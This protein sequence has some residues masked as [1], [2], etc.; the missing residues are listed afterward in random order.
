M[1][2]LRTVCLDFDGVV[3]QRGKGA[4]VDNKMLSDP[5][6]G[7]AE[8]IRQ[9]LERYNVVIST[10]RAASVLAREALRRFLVR[11][12]LTEVES[13]RVYI[14][15]LKPVADLYIGDRFY[16]LDN[17]PS[18]KDLEAAMRTDSRESVVKPTEWSAPIQKAIARIEEVDEPSEPPLPEEASPEP[19]PT[20]E[21][22]L[23]SRRRRS[24]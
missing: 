12:G 7:A 8:F 20:D 17:W 22:E 2:Q 14:T 19:E 23:K 10:E 11:A 13:G 6:P 1:A 24:R 9:L 5:R 3:H 18:T 15:P 4:L 21:P 16:R